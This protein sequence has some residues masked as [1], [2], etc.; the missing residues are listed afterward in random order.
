MKLHLLPPSMALLLSCL[1]FA[2]DAQPDASFGDNGIVSLPTISRLGVNAIAVR[3]DGKI[4]T[5]TGNG[6]ENSNS[7]VLRQYLPNGSPD[8]GFG[9]GGVAV[10]S[11]LHYF[12]D[13][14]NCMRLQPDGKIVVC[15]TT[16]QDFIHYYDFAVTRFNANGTPDTGFGVNGM[17]VNDFA[18]EMDFAYNV[19]IQPDGKIVA[20]GRAG[21]SGN[22]TGANF[23]IIRYNEN[24]TPDTG[25]GNNS[26]LAL[27]FSSDEPFTGNFATCAK[28]QDDGKILVGGSS[29]RAPY[30][31]DFAT[32]RLNADGSIDTAF[33][34]NGVARTGFDG[35]EYIFATVEA[36][37][38]LPDYSIV[39]AG[40]LN[41][42]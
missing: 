28:I 42:G 30:Q 2:Q 1:C 37:V 25:F 14:R 15:G 38:V 41:I 12:G 31:F 9:S 34:D 40:N 11:V 4:V 18:N 20:C 13:I 33:G 27:D 7:L 10:T 8:L 3:P 5:C 35:D 22:N 24:G 29:A 21:S 36:L 26:K 17:V 39:V 16:M 19:Q 6:V 32:V 23:G